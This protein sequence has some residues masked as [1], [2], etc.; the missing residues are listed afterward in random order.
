[1]SGE[2]RLRDFSLE[3]LDKEMKRRRAQE[4]NSSTAVLPRAS[5]IGQKAAE[6]ILKRHCFLTKEQRKSCGEAFPMDLAISLLRQHPKLVALPFNKETVFSYF[7]RAS[8]SIATMAE[9]CSMW[10][11]HAPK[12]SWR[13]R[14]KLTRTPNP[15]ADFCLFGQGDT[16]I[17]LL[18]M[19][20]FP[21]H[22]SD[23]FFTTTNGAMYTPL[24]YFSIVVP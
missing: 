5:N 11:A 2:K 9:I 13:N 24:Y 19:D 6:D 4:A 1:M 17:L 18:L 8:A 23:Y 10:K 12:L 22:L 14:N 3:D 21:N 20:A 16:E 15:V 7:L